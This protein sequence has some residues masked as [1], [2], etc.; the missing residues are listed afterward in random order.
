MGYV[1]L[2]NHMLPGLDD[3][4]SEISQSLELASGLARLGFELVCCT[5]HQRYGLFTPDLDLVRSG[6]R[7]LKKTF[8]VQGIDLDLLPGAENCY[9]ELFWR[10]AHVNEI[11][12]YGETKTFLVEF[13][14]PPV[15]PDFGVKLFEW[16]KQGYT[17]VLAHIER[18]GIDMKMLDRFR[19]LGQMAALSVNLDTIGGTWGRTY[20]KWAKRILSEGVVQVLT[21]DSHSASTLAATERGMTWVDKSMGRSALESFLVRNPREVLA[22]RLPDPVGG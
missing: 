2:H 12:C 3:G 21:T 5:S 22:G 11:P 7:S 18:Y 9:D 17:I 16:R 14:S 1:D 8:E 10:R 20:A 19:D 15:P 4:P 6:V 13:A